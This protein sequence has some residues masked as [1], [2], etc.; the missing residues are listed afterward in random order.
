MQREA[1]LPGGQ[2]RV[3]AHLQRALQEPRPGHLHREVRQRGRL[4]RA[5]R[6]LL[7]HL[8]GH[9]HRQAHLAR[10]AHQVDVA[11]LRLLGGR[12]HQP[13]R[14]LQQRRLQVD[15]VGDLEG[16]QRLVDRVQRRLRR[17]QLRRAVDA[18]A[19]A[20]VRREALRQVDQH[21]RHRH[22]AHVVALLLVE[23]QPVAHRLRD[24]LRQAYPR[25]RAAGLLSFVVEDG[26]DS[27]DSTSYG[28]WQSS[29]IAS[30]R[31]A[32]TPW[33]AMEAR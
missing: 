11:A 2:Q 10:A 8:V 16:H 32:T 28:S 3:H 5:P 14:R 9:L 15:A 29:S 33:H 4:Q 13:D 26:V 25:R 6:Q 31:D 12:V 22:Q 20:E 19:R 23:G 17:L 24:G 30:S 21:A 7:Q 27:V 18:V 1:G